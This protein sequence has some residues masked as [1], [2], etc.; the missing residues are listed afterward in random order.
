MGLFNPIGVD[1]VQK[2]DTVYA[3]LIGVWWLTGDVPL[4]N[5]AEVGDHAIAE[6]LA[7]RPWTNIPVRTGTGSDGKSTVYM[8]STQ[9]DSASMAALAAQDSSA[10]ALAAISYTALPTTT[11]EG[12][13]YYGWAKVLGTFTSF[14][15]APGS[16]TS[17]VAARRLTSTPTA[18]ATGAG[19]EMVVQVDP[20]QLG[21]AE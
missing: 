11:S 17:G 18:T 7:A 16:S 8:Q 21:S 5:G 19:G 9:L 13:V 10:S 15:Q 6:S 14:Y 2:V 1:S 3:A 12:T 4:T 20:A